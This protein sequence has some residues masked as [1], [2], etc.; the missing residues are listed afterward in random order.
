[1]AVNSTATSAAPVLVHTTIVDSEI[2]RLVAR[3][4]TDLFEPTDTV[5]KVAFAGCLNDGLS[6]EEIAAAAEVPA[7]QIADVLLSAPM[8]IR[9]HLRRKAIA[10][11][12]VLRSRA[13]SWT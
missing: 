10:R 12:L 11:C 4:V 6:V 8:L 7:G 9:A 13:D 1:M 5:T 3:L 2:V